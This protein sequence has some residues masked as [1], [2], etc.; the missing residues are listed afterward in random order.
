MRLVVVLLEGGEFLLQ[1]L[2]RGVIAQAR[3]PNHAPGIASTAFEF[4]PLVELLHDGRCG[5]GDVGLWVALQHVLERFFEFVV[6]VLGGIAQRVDKHELGHDFRQ[7]V[8]LHHQVVGR[9]HAIVVIVQVVGVGLLIEDLFLVGH[10]LEIVEIER[11]LHGLPVLGVGKVGEDV[12]S[13]P[14][15]GSGVSLAHVEQIHVVVHVEAVGV[16]GVSAQQV[17][18]FGGRGVEVVEFVLEDDAHVVESLLNHIVGRLDLFLGLGNLLE[19]IFFVMRVVLA[20]GSLFVDFGRVGA[21]HSG[22]V[23]GQF[24]VGQFV[25]A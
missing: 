4:A 13:I 2:G 10:V 20:L 7:R 3:A 21:R 15:G 24:I 25:V 22:R 14:L 18:E 6:V 11:V 17:V 9:V 8:F 12:I 16:V 1:G 5:A 19:V 23:A